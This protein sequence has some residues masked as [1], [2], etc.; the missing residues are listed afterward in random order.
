MVETGKI[1]RDDIRAHESAGILPLFSAC[2]KV[3]C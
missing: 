2:T 1:V 3:W